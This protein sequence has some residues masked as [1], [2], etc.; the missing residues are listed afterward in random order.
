MYNFVIVLSLCAMGGKMITKMIK[1][2]RLVLQF[3]IVISVT[4]KSQQ[5]KTEQF[6]AEIGNNTSFDIY[7]P[8]WDFAANSSICRLNEHDSVF[9]IKFQQLVPLGKEAGII[10]SD[11]TIISNP[12]LNRQYIFWNGR[13]GD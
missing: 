2:S 5:F 1:F 6:A 7:N 12:Q 9:T 3:T 8:M 4:T 10:I 13:G 11:T